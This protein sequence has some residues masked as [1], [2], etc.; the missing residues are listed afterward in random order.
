MPDSVEF[1]KGILLY[2]IPIHLSFHVGKLICDFVTYELIS[3]LNRN[4]RQYARSNGNV[5]IK[6]KKL[7]QRPLRMLKNCPPK[8]SLS[9]QTLAYIEI[10]ITRDIQR[11]EKAMKMNK[12]KHTDK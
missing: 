4:R 3:T 6:F 9:F 8:K 7:L 12:L 10:E 1:Y 11:G 2:F 5:Y